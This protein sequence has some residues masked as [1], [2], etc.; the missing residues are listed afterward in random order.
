MMKVIICKILI[1]FLIY[2]IAFQI[3]NQIIF[4]LIKINYINKTKVFKKII[5]LRQKINQTIT[6]MISHFKFPIKVKYILKYIFQD[7]Q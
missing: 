2:Q 1:A 7:D 3:L 4:N 5:N 6:L